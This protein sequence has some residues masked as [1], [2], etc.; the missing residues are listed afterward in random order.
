MEGE[1]DGM[2]WFSGSLLSQASK[3]SLA[4]GSSSESRT[5][6]GWSRPMNW[7]RV[8]VWYLELG[9]SPRVLRLAFLSNGSSSSSSSSLRRFTSPSPSVLLLFS[10]SIFVSFFRFL[11][12][13]D[14]GGSSSSLSSSFLALFGRRFSFAGSLC[15]SS[16]SLSSKSSPS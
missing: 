3:P 11:R 1:D 6:R 2:V 7:V 12:R 13:L 8:W 15:I 10:P 9:I 14:T 5:R 4:V 16:A